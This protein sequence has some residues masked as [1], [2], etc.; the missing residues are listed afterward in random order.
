MISSLQP[1]SCHV[2]MGTGSLL[3]VLEVLPVD[4]AVAVCRL[5]MPCSRA[6]ASQVD[7]FVPLCCSAAG[8]PVALDSGRLDGVC[9]RSL[10]L[11]GLLRGWVTTGQLRRA[12]A[13][14]LLERC[15]EAGGTHA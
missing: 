15:L 7:A 14:M 1:G 3:L 6:Q 9:L 2:S 8:V 4:A 12:E 11:A 10:W 13:V 5:S